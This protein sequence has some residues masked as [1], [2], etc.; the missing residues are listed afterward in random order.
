M[1]L[2]DG[3]VVDRS[4]YAGISPPEMR[5]IRRWEKMPVRLDRQLNADLVLLVRR[6]R[7]DDAVDGLGGVVRM[8]SRKH[9]VSRFGGGHGRGHGLRIAHFADEDDVDVFAKHAGQ[10]AE[11]KSI[12]ST[13]TSRWSMMDFFGSK[14]YSIG[15]SMVMMCSARSALIYSIIAARVVVLP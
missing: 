7:V 14:I 12:V 2:A 5:G 9:Q 8:K 15:S 6:K 4:S 11:P 3:V 13:R 10:S 1:R